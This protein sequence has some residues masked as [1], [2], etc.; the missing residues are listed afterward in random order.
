MAEYIR[1]VTVYFGLDLHLH[2]HIGSVP[3]DL[4]LIAQSVNF[5]CLLACF[6]AG[7]LPY[8]LIMTCQALTLD[9]FC[10]LRRL[11]S[12]IWAIGFGW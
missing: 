9:L 8:P 4:D 2:V 5:R 1:V 7:M 11:S 3:V 6:L 12:A 10:D